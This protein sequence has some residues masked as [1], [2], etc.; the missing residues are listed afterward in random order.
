MSENWSWFCTVISYIQYF[1]RNR[2][3][4]AFRGVAFYSVSRTLSAVIGRLRKDK[5]H[6]PP[7][8]VGLPQKKTACST[9]LQNILTFSTI[10]P[11][12]LSYHERHIV[13]I[14]QWWDV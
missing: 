5:Y 3:A 13:T 11:A 6:P 4:A 12:P 8:F 7:S 1:R 2:N 9:L 14:Q 10:L